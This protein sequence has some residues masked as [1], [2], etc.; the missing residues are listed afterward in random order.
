MGGRGVGKNGLVSVWSH[1]FLSDYNPV[2]EY[3]ISIVANTENKLKH[4]LWRYITA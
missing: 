3:D 2:D 4:H 1:F